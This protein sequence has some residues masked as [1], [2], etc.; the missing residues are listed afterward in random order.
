MSG[1]TGGRM[2]CHRTVQMRS[3]SSHGSTLHLVEEGLDEVRV[4]AHLA[5]HRSEQRV[6]GG[7]F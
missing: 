7:L 3:L 2:G 5:L 6:A 4:Q 1:L